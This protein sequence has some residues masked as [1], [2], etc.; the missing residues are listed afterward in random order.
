MFIVQFV[1]G[2]LSTALSQPAV[3][4]L[5]IIAGT[6]ILEDAT[7]VLV[8]VAVAAG[9]CSLPVALLSLYAGVILGDLGL[10]GLG[11]AASSHRWARRLARAE[12]LLPLRAWLDH[13]LVV[14]VFSARFMPGL[15]LPTYTA[16]GFF[17]MPLRRFAVGVIAATLVWTSLLFAGAV[18]FGTAT[19]DV[20]GQWRW[21][22]GVALTVLLLW[23]V[24]SS[25]QRR[26]NAG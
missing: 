1:A 16:T 4:P 22:V 12:R 25:L 8:G 23:L 14:A 21:P 5:A 9:Q 7:T 20:L 13:H 26:S 11:R 24:R 3:L 10:Y 6:F 2:L 17:G 15:R 18:L 19:E